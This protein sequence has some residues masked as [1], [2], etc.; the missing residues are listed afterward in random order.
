MKTLSLILNVECSGNDNLELLNDHKNHYNTNFVYGSHVS[1]QQID[2]LTN[3]F[4]SDK[5][6]KFLIIRDPRDFVVSLSYWMKKNNILFNINENVEQPAIMANLILSYHTI[7]YHY[8]LFALR[9]LNSDFLI[10]RFED[11]IGSH[12]NSTYEKQKET[13]IKI[14]RH[15]ELEPSDE[16]LN[17]VINNLFGNSATFREGKIGSWKNEFNFEQKV[18]FHKK[19]NWLISALGYSLEW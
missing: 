3:F 7:L 15:L 8:D 1:F 12:G 18:F 6:K 2:K 17:H 5:I 4:N 16:L 9:Y 19:Y 11:L 10:V 14:I 13:L